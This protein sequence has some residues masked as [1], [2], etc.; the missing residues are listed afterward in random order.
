[1]A[2]KSAS[3]TAAIDAAQKIVRDLAR[4][5]GVA[6]ADV[7]KVLEQLGI[8]RIMPQAI[9]ANQGRAIKAD[10]IKLAVRI[11]KNAIIV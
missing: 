3:K 4:S 6:E 2:T 11:G 1:M 9:A 8:A 10:A 7:T 5:S